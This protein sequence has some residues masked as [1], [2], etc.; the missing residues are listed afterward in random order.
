[1]AAGG[2]NESSSRLNVSYAE[3]LESEYAGK[4]ENCPVVFVRIGSMID[5]ATFYVTQV[6]L[7]LDDLSGCRLGMVSQLKSY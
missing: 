1:M 7:G 5:A 6:H 2:V 3:S 4:P